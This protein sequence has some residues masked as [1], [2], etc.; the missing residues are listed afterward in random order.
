MSSSCYVG[1]W[2]WDVVEAGRHEANLTARPHGERG[3]TPAQA[4]RAAIKDQLFDKLL[5]HIKITV[6]DR[7]ITGKDVKNVFTAIGCLEAKTTPD[8]AKKCIDLLCSLL[9]PKP[10]FCLVFDACKLLDSCLVATVAGL[11]QLI[12]PNTIQILVR[13]MARCRL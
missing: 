7:D 8:V 4:W 13:R 5:E 1:L 9:K 12:I 10:P 6:K 11:A 2:T 3:P